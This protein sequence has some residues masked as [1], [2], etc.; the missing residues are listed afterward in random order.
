MG[1][2]QAYVVRPLRALNARI[3]NLFVV[4][5][6]S[7]TSLSYVDGL[8]AI[9][10]MMVVALHVW[11]WAPVPVRIPLPLV[12]S[13]DLTP[14]VSHGGY[15]VQLFFVLSGFLLA[16][17]WHRAHYLA[18]PA[19][20]VRTYFQL[21]LFRIVPA[22]YAC[23]FLM[24][25]FFT[26]IYIPTTLL[27]S[28]DGLLTVIT[29]LLFLQYLTPVSSTSFLIDRPFWTLTME[30]QFYLIL[31]LAVRLFVGRRWL[32]ALPASGA[33]SLVWLHACRTAFQPLVNVVYLAMQRDVQ[34]HA[35]FDLVNANQ[36]FLWQFPAQVILFA[37]GISIS[38]LYVW[39]SLRRPAHGLVHTLT[40]SYAGVLYFVLGWVLI[41]AAV[42]PGSPLL[43]FL[44]STNLDASNPVAFSWGYY[45]TK[46]VLGL[47]FAL[48][49][50]GAAFGAGWLKAILSV[51]P[52]RVI[53]V[54]S[55]SIYLWHAPIIRNWIAF[56][57]PSQLPRPALLQHLMATVP[58]SIFLLAC[59]LYLA[60]EKPFMLMARRRARAQREKAA[61]QEHA[62]AAVNA[63]EGEATLAHTGPGSAMPAFAAVSERG[64]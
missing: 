24:L 54:V 42:Y 7:G 10:V 17:A 39:Y 61:A 59:F 28:G 58:L 45:L 49:V 11:G 64:S 23:I 43:D 27:F 51:T 30:M 16:Q 20:R 4:E 32:I 13:L 3:L 47:G 25:L 1:V 22:Y 56:F 15:G 9:A 60:I 19:P 50:L 44:G 18:K 12:P 21:R 57:Q 53:G 35:S 38:N 55:Y 6:S 5:P 2:A 33:I 26:G 34:L 36:F 52:L 40:G 14:I 46:P 63:R 62:R 31:P 41:L 37:I 48:I 8:R 29:H